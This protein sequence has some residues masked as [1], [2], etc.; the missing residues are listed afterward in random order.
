M[1]L[2][3]WI[4]L[5]RF[6]SNPSV[7]SAEGALAQ[8]GALGASVAMGL[9]KL[10]AKRAEPGLLFWPE[11]LSLALARSAFSPRQGQ[12]AAAL[13]FEW[14]EGPLFRDE[15][16]NL[17]ARYWK[18]E[19]ASLEVGGRRRLWALALRLVRELAAAGASPSSAEFNGHKSYY[20]AEMCLAAFERARDPEGLKRRMEAN[21]LAKDGRLLHMALSSLPWPWLADTLEGLKQGALRE[22]SRYDDMIGF[23]VAVRVFAEGRLDERAVR[24][25]NLFPGSP[26]LLALRL[27]HPP[28]STCLWESLDHPPALDQL[29]L[30]AGRRWGWPGA[31][32][33][34][35]ASVAFDNPNASVSLFRPALARQARIT[36]W[37]PAID[38]LVSELG[39]PDQASMN[40]LWDSASIR[41]PLERALLE[42]SLGSA[43]AP[44]RRSIARV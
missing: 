25:L 39:L 11:A 35:R 27:S 1:G 20:G 10:M 38:A 15:S 42:R 30:D 9:L 13:F 34:M 12:R 24:I 36:A 18:A 17:E 19:D 23:G 6:R 14:L 3:K 43:P 32:S 41:A 26:D 22:S 37:S 33:V 4:A 5:A 21:L 2:K 44:R 8:P 7:E 16:V 31:V 29:A 28:S 40:E